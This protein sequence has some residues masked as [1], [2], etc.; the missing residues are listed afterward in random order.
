MGRFDSLI[1]LEEKP[2]PVPSP[3]EQPRKPENL[4]TGKPES[5]KSS[6]PES[7]KSGK[8]ENNLSGKPETLKPRFRKARKRKSIQH[9]CHQV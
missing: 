7:Q 9:N 4:K 3:V 1:Q 2:T 8:P 5:M 6:L